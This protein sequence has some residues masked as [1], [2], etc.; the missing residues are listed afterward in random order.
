M[1][2]KIIHCSDIH[3]RNFRRH[4]E[5][6]EQLLKFIEK[7]RN[8]VNEYGEDSVRIVICGDIVHSKTELSPECYTLVSWFLKEMDKLC[9]TIVIAGNHD[10]TT[11]QNRIDPLSVIFSM[12]KFERVYYLDKD[13]GYESGVVE[14]ENILWSLYSIFDSFNRPDVNSEKEGKTVVGLFHGDIKNAKTDLGYVSENGL[15]Y[16]VFDGV[17]VGMFGH[18]HKRQTIT[19]NGIPLVYSG[20]LIQQDQGENINGHGFVLWDVDSLEYEPIDIE[21]D[22][23]CQYVIN[24]N[25]IEDIDNDKEDFLNY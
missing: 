19:Y 3:I 16:S 20:S 24:I 11:N 12:C 8:I 2:K 17:D 23:Y 9:K 22:K 1:V 4:D 25:S 14:D 13:L 6:Q 5:Y 7:S 15:N 10:I 18:I 21:N